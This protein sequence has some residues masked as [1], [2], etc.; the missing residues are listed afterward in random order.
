MKLKFRYVVTA[1]LVVL[2]VGCDDKI[3]LFEQ[4]GSTE[5]PAVIE[6]EA[7]KSKALPG[8]ILLTWEVPEGNFAYL[9][10]KYYDPLTKKDVYKIASKGTTEMLIDNTRARYGNYKFYFQT[11]NVAHQGGEV[12]IIEATSGA[13]PIVTTVGKKSKIALTGDQLSSNAQ[14][15]T[16]GP[17][18]NL[19]DGNAGSFFHTRWSGT[20]IALPHYIQVD[21]KEPHE[22]FSIYYMNRNDSWT[23]SAR[24]SV[25]E[26]QISNDGVNW[27]TLTTL[28]GL[29]SAASAEYTSTYVAPGKTFTHFRFNVIATSGNTKYFNMAEFAMYDVELNVYDPETDEED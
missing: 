17:I 7:V 18:K 24:P 23:T 22:N 9:K 11:F 28:S 3:E 16:E 5:A 21:L 15:P 27:E 29:P 6:A 4:V 25:V 14:E 26:L 12:K 19:V 2:T 20:Q 10:I 8:Q 1:L 13:A